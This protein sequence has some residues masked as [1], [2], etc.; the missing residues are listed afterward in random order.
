MAFPLTVGA[1]TEG[2]ESP[3]LLKVVDVDTFIA[4]RWRPEHCVLLADEVHERLLGAPWGALCGRPNPQWHAPWIERP[5]LEPG[6]LPG[7]V[8]EIVPGRPNIRIAYR[9]GQRGN[10]LF[11]TERC[12]SFCLMCSQPP[13]QLAD[14]WRV[15]HNLQLVEL[16]DDDLPNLAITGG[17]PT[18]LGDGL[19]RMV[20]ACASRLPRTRLEILSNGRLFAAPSHLDR[21][22]DIGHPDIQWNIPLYADVASVHDYV[23]QSRGAFEQTCAGLVRL[24]E[25]KQAIEIRIVLHKASIPRLVETARF[26]FRNFTFARHIALMGLEPIG[27]TLANRDALWIDPADYQDELVEAVGFLVQQGMAVS[28]YNLPLCTLDRRLWPFSRQ[29]ISDWKNIY[30]PQCEGCSARTRCGGFFAS[31]SEQWVSR[32]VAPIATS[33]GG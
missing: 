9:R 12:N 7:D 2:F 1:K 4:G 15:N 23:V 30:L 8:I 14:D 28:F 24:A 19:L 25:M 22:A 33:I 11:A 26:I 17:E 21:V 13:R 10:V 3:R 5:A 32:K 6:F 27:F 29:S 31:I 18:L 16:I 20:E